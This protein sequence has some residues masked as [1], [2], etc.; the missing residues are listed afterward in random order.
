ME[1]DIE[2]TEL[3]KKLN[4]LEKENNNIKNKLKQIEKENRQITESNDA[5]FN[6]LYVYHE[7]KPKKLLQNSH[8]IILQMLDFIDNVC[9]KYNLKWF[10]SQA[11]L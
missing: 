1:P 7:L 2:T 5:L 3:I 4:R 9:K 11:V 8:E 6:N 10:W